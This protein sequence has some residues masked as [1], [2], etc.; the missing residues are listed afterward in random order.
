[1]F[2]SETSGRDWR[3]FKS[4]TRSRGTD[5]AMGPMRLQA[6]RERDECGCAREREKQAGTEGSKM[7][8]LKAIS[9]VRVQS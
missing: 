4:R 2:D 8:W 6:G 1:M 3:L 9:L 7:L 5:R